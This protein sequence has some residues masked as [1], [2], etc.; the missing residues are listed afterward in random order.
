MWALLMVTFSNRSVNVK[1]LDMDTCYRKWLQQPLVSLLCSKR[2][3][4]A[5]K[6]LLFFQMLTPYLISKDIVTVL[7]ADFFKV[8]L[9]NIW[10]SLEVIHDNPVY[11]PKSWPVNP[12]DKTARKVGKPLK[13]RT[14]KRY[15]YIL[16]NFVSSLTVK[17][18]IWSVVLVTAYSHYTGTGA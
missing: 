13:D 1:S 2:V 4:L 17:S 3:S 14:I 10:G 9:K 16:S 15:I 11:T 18:F 5:G 6:F 7:V 12:I 8:L